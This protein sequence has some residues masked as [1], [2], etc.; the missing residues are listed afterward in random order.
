MSF[1]VAAPEAGGQSQFSC[2]SPGG[3]Q[4]VQLDD[5]ASQMPKDVIHAIDPSNALGLLNFAHL[6]HWREHAPNRSGTFVQSW[7]KHLNLKQWK[8]YRFKKTIL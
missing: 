6:L 7:A 3:G 8:W 1:G 5:V 4:I 2:P